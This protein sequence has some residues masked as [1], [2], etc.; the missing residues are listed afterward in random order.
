LD[1]WLKS[2]GLQPLQADPCVYIKRSGND[3]LMLVVHVDDQLIACNSRDMLD[4]FKSDLNA[5]FECS[6]SDTANY[7]L[8]FNIF[9][10]RSQRKLFISQEHY[11]EALLEK[12]NMTNANPALNIMPSGFKALPATDEEFATVSHLPYPSIA[13]AILYASTISRPDLS[14]I[15]GVMCRYISKWNE[16]H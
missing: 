3:F 2:Q 4:N 5:Q 13:G 10:D 11:L 16:D 7:F 1:K 12:H 6:D 14:F 15:A 8:G 9:R